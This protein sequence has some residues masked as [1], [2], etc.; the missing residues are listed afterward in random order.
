MLLLVA[1][2]AFGLVVAVVLKIVDLVAEGRGSWTRRAIAADV[3][4]LKALP[5]ELRSSSAGTALQGRV[6]RSLAVY[7]AEQPTNEDYRRPAPMPSSDRSSGLNQVISNRAQSI[8]LKILLVQGLLAGTL[9]ILIPDAAT[10]RETNWI[11]VVGVLI[12]LSAVEI[13]VAYRF[14][15]WQ[16]TRHWRQQGI[17]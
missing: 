5:P 8:F 17:L 12:C 4:L 10:D 6:E 14:A 3:E 7:S 16:V 2:S 11:V 13:L 1:G 15:R 9:S